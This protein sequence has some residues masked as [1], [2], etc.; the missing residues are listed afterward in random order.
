MKQGQTRFPDLSWYFSDEAN[1]G[2]NVTQYLVIVEDPDAPLPRLVGHGTY[3]AIP[4]IRQDH[5]AAG[6]PAARCGQ[7]TERAQWVS[8][9]AES[10]EEYLAWS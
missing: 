5:F 10:D 4:S 8:V 6:R 3:Y 2:K 7:K 1:V 9:G